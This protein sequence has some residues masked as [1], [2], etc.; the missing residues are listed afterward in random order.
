MLL[1]SQ[2]LSLPFL[3]PS[4]PQTQLWDVSTAGKL[5]Q[6]SMG[7]DP[8]LDLA[9]FQSSDTPVLTA[10]TESK[11]HVFQWEP[12]SQYSQYMLY[13]SFQ[14]LSPFSG[15]ECHNII[16]IS[17]FKLTQCHETKCGCASCKYY[18]ISNR[19]TVFHHSVLNAH[20]T[21]T[22]KLDLFI[23]AVCLP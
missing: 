6:L 13:T 20:S 22:K 1:F 14:F 8:T 19:A 10:L 7:G 2:F 9:A 23:R 5:Q 15:P 21:Y 18:L 3:L 16:S 11:L 17:Q 12:T 4:F